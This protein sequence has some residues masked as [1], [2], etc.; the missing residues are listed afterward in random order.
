M[1]D[2][3]STRCDDMMWLVSGVAIDRRLASRALEDGFEHSVERIARDCKLESHRFL[4][5][6]TD[7]NK[8]ISSFDIKCI[9]IKIKLISA[10]QWSTRSIFQYVP[11]KV[12]HQY[13]YRACEVKHAYYI[14][15]S[16]I[17]SSTNILVNCRVR[18]KYDPISSIA[19]VCKTPAKM[20]QSQ[21][22]LL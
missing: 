9:R 8:P 7:H 10:K 3:L 6:Q 11:W 4:S 15:G 2:A 14:T 5:S 21:W 12:N 18:A 16:I 1:H 17:T 13:Q 20:I 19:R 22:F